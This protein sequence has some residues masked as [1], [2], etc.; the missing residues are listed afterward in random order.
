[1]VK[2]EKLIEENF[3]ETQERSLRP[4]IVMQIHDELIYEVPLSGFDPDIRQPITSCFSDVNV[5]RFSLLLMNYMTKTVVNELQLSIPLAANM[6]L[7][8][9]WGNLVDFDCT[10][11]IETK[12]AMGKRSID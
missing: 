3:I 1:M 4:K 6:T 8:Y 10:S 5:S 11:T 9:D 2:V 7:G 12:K